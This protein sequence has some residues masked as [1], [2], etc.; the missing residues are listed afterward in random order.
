MKSN[1]VA[2]KL[3]ILLPIAMITSIAAPATGADLTEQEAGELYDQ[4]QRHMWA[5]EWD[6]ALPC[7]VKLIDL[8]EPPETY[9]FVGGDDSNRDFYDLGTVL[10]GLERVPKPGIALNVIWFGI[11]W[12]GIAVTLRTASGGFATVVTGSQQHAHGYNR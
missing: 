4:W 12:F 8:V 6:A 10:M 1:G 9:A 7:L 5:Q 2:A 3:K 11:V